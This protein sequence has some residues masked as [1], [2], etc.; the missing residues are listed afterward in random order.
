MKQ[1]PSRLKFKKNHKLKKSLFYLK[2]QKNFLPL[3]GNFSLR[4]SR[5]CKISFL[6]IEAIRKS[7]RRSLKKEGN[8]VMRLFTNFS[9]TK[10]PLS[11]RMGK[12]KGSH[13][14]WVCPVRAGQVMC[15]IGNI[16]H[17]RALTALRSAVRKLPVKAIISPMV[18]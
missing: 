11:S 1:Y 15:E 7:I 5:S 12:G 14:I 9:V 6:Q 13:S 10:K 2:D 16:K 3:F 8:V 17:M 18:Y 4:F